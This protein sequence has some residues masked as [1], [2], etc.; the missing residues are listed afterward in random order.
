[1]DPTLLLSHKVEGTFSLD[2]ANIRHLAIEF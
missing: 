1:M 2:V